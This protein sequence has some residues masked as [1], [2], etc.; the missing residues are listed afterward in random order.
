[1]VDVNNEFYYRIARADNKE[2]WGEGY[3]LSTVYDP[4]EGAAVHCIIDKTTGDV[5]RSVQIKAK[6][7]GSGLDQV[8]WPTPTSITIV[9]TT[10]LNLSIQ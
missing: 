4:V 1:M 6:Q 9:A 8:T 5:V 2:Q 7:L 10:T 3:Y